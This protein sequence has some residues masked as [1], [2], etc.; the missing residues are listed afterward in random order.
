MPKYISGRFKKTPQSAL[1]ADRYRYLSV[2]DSEP[3]LGDSP[4]DQGTPNLPTG[5]QYIVVGFRDRPGERFW[6]PNQGGLIPGSLSVFEEGTL[7]GGLSSTTQLNFVGQSITAEGVGGSDPGVAVTIT[8]APPGNPNEVLFVGA[9]GTDFDTDTRFTF[10]NGLF[11]AGDR[12]TVGTGGTVI[13]TTGIGSVGIGTTEPTQK[14]HLNG[15]FRI[16]GTIYDSTNQPGSQGDLLVKGAGENLIWVTQNAVTSGA[17]GTIGQIQFHSTAGVV[18]G[19]DNFYFDFNNNRVGIGS[20]QPTQ[21]LDVLGVSIFTGDVNFIGDN[22]NLLW[23]KSQDSLEFKDETKATFGDGRDLQISH[24]NTL[25]SQTDSNGDS[26]VDGRTSFIEE[27]GS[28]GLIFKSNGGDGPGAYQFF[29][30]NWHPLLKLHGGTNARALLFHN[31]VERIE[32]TGYGVTING[33]LGVSGIA[34]IQTLNLQNLSVPGISTLGN[35]VVNTNTIST[36]SGTGNLI[37]DS[38]GSVEIK[39]PLLVSGATESTSK[40]SG[41]IITEG[42]IGVEKSVNIGLKLNVGDTVSFSGPSVGIA[43]T[44]AGAGGITTTGGDLYVNGNVLPSH[45]ATSNNDSSGK[46]IG[47]S[48]INWRKVYAQEFVGGLAGNADKATNLAGGA[49]GSIPYQSASDTTVF[50]AEPNADNKVLSYNNTSDAPTWIDLDKIEEG[51]TSAEVIDTG[52]DGHFK[53]TTEGSERLRIGPNGQIGLSGA[54]YGTANKVLTSNGPS[55]APTW[56]SISVPDKI[57]EGNT[58]AEVVDT[59]GDGHFK[60]ITEGTERLRIG[61]AG[62]IGLGGANYGSATQVLTSNG[63]SAAPTWQPIP[64]ASIP[65]KIEEGNTKAEVV[66]TNGNGHFFVETEGTERF[67]IDSTGTATF[68]ADITAGSGNPGQINIDPTT[69]TSNGRIKYSGTKTFMIEG[70]TNSDNKIEIH[71]HENSLNILCEGEGETE[72]YY[73]G[74]K[75]LA[76]NNDGISVTGISG[77]TEGFDFGVKSGGSLVTTNSVKTLNFSGSNNTITYDAS[78]KTVDIDIDG[79]SGSGGGTVFSGT[80]TASAGSPST[81]NTYAYDSAELVFEYTVFVKNGSDYQTQKLLVMRDGTTVDS[82]QYAV[83]YSNGLLVQLD[84]TIS[85]SNILLRATPGTGV[86][87]STTYKV[88][89]EVI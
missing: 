34:T 86:S 19:A 56:Q 58:S 88:K 77:A 38:D 64:G 30:Q 11:A 4:T 53:V 81:L 23:D 80:F 65:D 15:N 82:T 69:S 36:K 13:T 59:N 50:L 75:K 63:S 79:S 67:R 42:G 7:V 84:A 14:L 54:N 71:G 17:G 61:S 31:G 83:M 10:N 26:I 35:V 70:G 48:N 22:Y 33:G 3:N 12:I 57:E 39:D 21:L 49:A 1:P 76:T 29:D 5:Q 62:Q 68:T 37:I 44:L 9:G 24:T 20:T 85:G 47:A 51:N 32:T 60:V 45:D 28:G 72:L 66:D 16:T 78:T 73:N 40:D 89:R 74:N 8:V 18:D 46:D 55:A 41:S 6:I 43:V 2:G 52:S 27:N 87:G 25:S